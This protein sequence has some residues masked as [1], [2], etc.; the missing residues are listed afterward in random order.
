MAFGVVVGPAVGVAGF[1]RVWGSAGVAGIC[2]CSLA[3]QGTPGTCPDVDC[4]TIPKAHASHVLAGGVQAR[5][6]SCWPVWQDK[7]S[8]GSQ[9][10]VNSSLGWRVWTNRRM[11]CTCERRHL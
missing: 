10:Q 11:A 8:F 1:Y 3:E 7:Q 9:L 6:S 4:F 5:H 2:R